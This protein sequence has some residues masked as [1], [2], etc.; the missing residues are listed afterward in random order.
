MYNSEQD[1][2]DSLRKPPTIQNPEPFLVKLIFL[3]CLQMMNGDMKS[4]VKA[5]VIAKTALSV[6]LDSVFEEKEIV[7]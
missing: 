5:A 4:A 6:W 7:H 1:V 3:S 2:V